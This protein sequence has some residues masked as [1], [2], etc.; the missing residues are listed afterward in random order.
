MTIFIPFLFSV[1]K[2]NSTVDPKIAILIPKED[3]TCYLL[4]RQN[5]FKILE[6]NK[7]PIRG[8]NHPPYQMD[9]G[10]GIHDFTLSLKV[11]IFALRSDLPGKKEKVRKN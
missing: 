4:Q 6:V 3:T 1:V 2:V 11:N 10:R 8:S 9:G 7:N 5:L